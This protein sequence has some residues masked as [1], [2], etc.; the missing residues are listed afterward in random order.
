M[1]KPTHIE[2]KSTHPSSAMM[3]EDQFITLA[4]IRELADIIC[5][6]SQHMKSN[7]SQSDYSKSPG[8]IDALAHTIGLLAEKVA[9]DNC[10]CV[11]VTE[12]IR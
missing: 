2:R 7:N 8:R 9:T 3:S 12:V 5:D 6:Y 1:Y 10:E 4:H 11:H